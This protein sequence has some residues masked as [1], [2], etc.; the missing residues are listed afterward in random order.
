VSPEHK[1]KFKEHVEEIK[2]DYE[3]KYKVHF[4]ITYSEQKASTDTIAVDPGNNPFKNEDGSLL[5]RPAG[6]GALIE[7]LNDIDADV[8]FI[9]NIDNVVPDKFKETT[10][11]YKKVLGGILLQYQSKIFDYIHVLQLTPSAEKLNEIQIFVEDKLCINKGSNDQENDLNTQKEYLLKKLNR[12]IRVCG[13]VKNEGE[14]GGG[15]FW[16]QNNDGTISLQI[17]ESSQ[18]DQKD[19]QQNE[20]LKNST[21]F[22]P[23]DLVCSLK[24]YNKEKFDLLKFRDPATGFITEKSKDGKELKAQELPGL[25]NG[26]MSDWITIFLEVPIITFNPVKS[27]ND[28]LRDEHQN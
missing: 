27:V 22:N 17:V 18:V 19:P 23:V 24:N 14:A 26:A 6:H 9:K 11:T 1:G 7:N 25:W 20:I 8:V 21:H 13:M 4:D 16:A 28:L 2:S 15:P 3:Q 10:F 5:F 12:P